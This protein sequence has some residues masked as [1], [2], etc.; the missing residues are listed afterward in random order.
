VQKKGR[1]GNKGE[2]QSS[3]LEEYIESP[4][5]RWSN[6]KRRRSGRDI[7]GKGKKKVPTVKVHHEGVRRRV[8]RRWNDERGGATEKRV[9]D[10]KRGGV[11]T[12]RSEA[13]HIRLGKSLKGF[14][15][16]EIFF[17]QTDG[18]SWGV[19]S[20][21]PESGEITC[22]NNDKEEHKLRKE[23]KKK[24]GGKEG[25]ERKRRRRA[26]IKESSGGTRGGRLGKRRG[27]Y[28][29]LPRTTQCRK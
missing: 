23:R 6:N 17:G 19:T 9:E 11:G 1:K 25:K 27:K 24:K 10:R 26:E 14:K 5:M 16:C 4:E 28:K 8:R 18:L 22:R 13:R 7:R 20:D 15:K 12:R 21:K 2:V 29:P 3:I